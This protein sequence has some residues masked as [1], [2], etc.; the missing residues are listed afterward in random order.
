MRVLDKLA[1]LFAQMMFLC[2]GL[3][4]DPEQF[5]KNYPWDP[6][7]VYDSLVNYC[8]AVIKN[9]NRYAAAYKPNYWYF[10]AHGWQG[11]RALETVCDL[12]R[13]LA[14]NAVLIIDGKNG[15]ID[16]TAKMAARMVLN[17]FGA[18]AMTANAYMGSDAIL[19]LAGQTGTLEGGY[20]FGERPLVFAL[21]LT[22]N[23]NNEPQNLPV[24]TGVGCIPMSVAMTQL[25]HEWHSNPE[26]PNLGLVVGATKPEPAKRVQAA[27]KGM[28]K[29]V[30]GL[31]KQKGDLVATVAAL[32][33]DNGSV[34]AL[35]N[36]SSGIGH[37]TQGEDFE[38][39]V[40][41]ATRGYHIDIQTTI[42]QASPAEVESANH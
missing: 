4:P 1:A 21:A 17:P 28:I 25:L 7:N 9:T 34:L 2:V 31:G 14:P 26:Y 10:A 11:I 27:G 22:S 41:R 39:Q 8:T 38:E 29:L 3:D 32:R 15:D 40:E 30:P 24:Q 18:D 16:R 12:I 37:V 35:F 19:T 36:V 5:P 6:D 42:R 33:E 13:K 23:P 20:M